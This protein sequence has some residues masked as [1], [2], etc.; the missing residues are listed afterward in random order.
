MHSLVLAR[1]ARALGC[2][3]VDGRCCRSSRRYTLCLKNAPTLASCSFDKYELILMI[4]DRQH[5]HTFKNDAHIQLSSFLHF[6][7]LCL[8][9]NSCDVNDATP[10]T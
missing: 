5:Q 7:L 2:D 6:S 8:L 3:A 4:L 9:L 10:A 1:D